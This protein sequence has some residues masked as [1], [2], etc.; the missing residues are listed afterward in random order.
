MLRLLVHDTVTE[1]GLAS[2][3][4]YPVFPTAKSQPVSAG[5]GLAAATIAQFAFLSYDIV[6]CCPG[7]LRLGPFNLHTPVCCWRGCCQVRLQH[8]KLRPPTCLYVASQQPHFVVWWQPHRPALT[9]I[10]AQPA[11][12]Q[13]CTHICLNTWYVLLRSTHEFHC[14]MCCTQLCIRPRI[15]SGVLLRMY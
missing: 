11:S 8:L 6:P 10:L 14:W 7:D 1:S 5:R 2:A 12:R 13:H 9:S 4:G 15:L 3:A